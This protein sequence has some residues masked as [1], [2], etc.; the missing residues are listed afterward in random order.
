MV[1]R[2]LASCRVFGVVGVLEL[3]EA[4]AGPQATDVPWPIRRVLCATRQKLEDAQLQRVTSINACKRIEETVES[5][6]SHVVDHAWLPYQVKW[7][8]SK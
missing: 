4:V 2:V 6:V 7:R 3:R 1:S 8:C 5:P